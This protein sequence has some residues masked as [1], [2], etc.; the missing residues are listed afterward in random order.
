MTPTDK[1]DKRNGRVQANMY[2]DEQVLKTVQEKNV[3]TIRLQFQ[4]SRA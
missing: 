2:S 3:E 4:T 1:S